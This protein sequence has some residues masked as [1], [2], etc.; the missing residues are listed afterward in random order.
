M[1]KAVQKNEILSLLNIMEWLWM[2]IEKEFEENEIGLPNA[3]L[4]FLKTTSLHESELIYIESIRI[5]F[6]LME[7]LGN[8][9]NSYAPFF[10]RILINCFSS[11]S[12][13]KRL[14]Y[15]CENFKESFQKIQNLPGGPLVEPL[16]RRLEE[17]VSFTCMDLCVNLLQE[18]RL[19]EE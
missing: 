10:Y 8:R 13:K 17:K 3:F 5:M 11:I 7:E 6:S 9:K 19:G 16:I 12:D 18:N 2:K 1:K 4:S 14:E 15:I